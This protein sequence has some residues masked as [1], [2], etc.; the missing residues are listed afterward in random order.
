VSISVAE[1]NRL[2]DGTDL[3][4]LFEIFPN[5]TTDLLKIKTNERNTNLE[6][7]IYG[8]DGNLFYQKGD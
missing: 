2:K 6:Y 8:L 3:N 5:R 4:T 7:A 1:A